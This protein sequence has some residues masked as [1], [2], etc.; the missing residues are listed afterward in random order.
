MTRP[1]AEPDYWPGTERIFADPGMV[2]LKDCIFLE[3]RLRRIEDMRT[4]G[5]G[6]TS[7]KLLVLDGN[8]IWHMRAARNV[9]RPI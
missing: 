4:P 1:A 9:F 3:G 2:R 8:E 6:P 7:E 5:V